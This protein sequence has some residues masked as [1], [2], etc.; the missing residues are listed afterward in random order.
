MRVLIIREAD[1]KVRNYI[2]CTMTEWV[3]ILMLFALLVFGIITA[4]NI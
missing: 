3:I 2:A 1:G 4:I